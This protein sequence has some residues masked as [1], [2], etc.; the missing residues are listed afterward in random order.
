MPTLTFLDQLSIYNAKASLAITEAVQQENVDKANL[1]SAL[2]STANDLNLSSTT[3]LT[4]LTALINIGDLLEKALPPYFPLTV[5]YENLQKYAGIHNDL[6]GLDQGN[7]LHLTTQEKTTLF[8]KAGLSD[9]TWGNLQGSYT[10]NIEFAALF[11]QKQQQLNG[12]GL[13][14]ANGTSI[15]YDNTTYLTSASLS[16]TAAGGGL[17]GFYPNPGLSNNAVITQQLT[18]FDPLG[19]AGSITSADTIVSAIQKLNANLLTVSSGVG[20]ISSVSFSMPS[21][22]FNYTAGPYLSGAAPLSATFK[23]QAQNSVFAGPIGGGTGQPDFRALIAADLPTS[24]T[25]T[26]TFGSNITI[27]VITVDA[28]GRVTNISN[29]SSSSGGQVNTV[30]F[31]VPGGGVFTAINGGTPADVEIG[32]GLG[33]QNPN[34][35]W[36]GPQ[37]GSATAPGF[38]ALVAADI[39][40]GIPQANIDNLPSALNSK[41]S[42]GLN[43]SLIYMGNGSG[44]AAQSKVAGDLTAVYSEPSGINTATFTIANKAVTYAKFADV[45]DSPSNAIRPI[46]L[47]RFSSGQG[48]MQQMTLDPLAFNYN[49]TSGEIGLLVPNPPSLVD[50]GDLLTSS[51]ANVLERLPLPVD[52]ATKGYLLTPYVG[53]TAPLDIKLIWGEVGGDLTYSINTTGTPFPEFLIG[54]NKVTL[55]K[56]QTI[57]T[58][59][60]LGNNAVGAAIPAALTPENVVAM[61][62]LQ[63]SITGLTKGVVP[64]SSFTP[65][66]GKTKQDYFLAANNTW[67]LGVGGTTLPGGNDLQI[68]WND[69]GAFGGLNNMA[70]DNGSNTFVTTGTFGIVDDANNPN[71]GVY[72]SV[73]N[74]TGGAL[75]WAIPAITANDTFVGEDF[76]QSLK[77]KTLSSGTKIDIGAP[78]PGTIWYSSDSLGTLTSLT[79]AGNANKYLRVNAGGTALEWAGA[80]GGI[81]I[82]DPITGATQGSVLF[83]GIGGILEQ[84]NGDFFY[85][86]TNKFLGIGTAVPE[87]GLH[88]V[89]SGSANIKGIMNMHFDS[90]ADNQAKFIGARGRGNKNTPSALLA[91]DRI[92][93]LSARGYKTSAW[94]D[95]VGGFYIY[96]SEAWTN[97]AT[98]TYLTF[99]GAVAGG[100][101]VSEW[102]R[103]TATSTVSQLALGQASSKTGK[104][105]LYSSGGNFTTAIQA[106]AGAT[107]SETYI[108]PLTDGSSGEVLSTNGSGQ[109]AWAAAGSVVDGTYGQ[110]TVSGGGT[111]WTPV[112]IDADVTNNFAA[113]TGPVILANATGVTQQPS[114]STPT[115]VTAILDVF[116]GTSAVATAK[117]LVPAPVLVTDVGKFLRA[118][119]TWQTVAGSGDMVLASNQLNIGVKTFAV[120]SLAIRNAGATAS[121]T[122]ATAASAAR[123]ATLPDATGTLAMLSLAQTWTAAQTFNSSTL[124]LRNAGNTQTTTIA[125]GATAGSYI[126]TIPTLTANTSFAVLNL[127][128]TF[129]TR[130]TVSWANTTTNTTQAQITNTD[131]GTQVQLGVGITLSGTSSTPANRIGVWADWNTSMIGSGTLGNN[132]NFVVA[133]NTASN[134][135][136]LTSNTGNIYHT[137]FS[138]GLPGGIYFGNHSITDNVARSSANNHYKYFVDISP[139]AGLTIS[140]AATDLVVTGYIRYSANT[141]SL[142][143]QAFSIAGITTTNPYIGE[144]VECLVPNSGAGSTMTAARIGTAQLVNSQGSN[145][146]QTYNSL[147]GHF[148]EYNLNS[149]GNNTG[150][151]NY[152]QMVLWNF[153]PG[154]SLATGVATMLRIRRSVGGGSMLSKAAIYIDNQT[155]TASITNPR[156]GATVTTGQTYANPPWSVF[157]ESDK[158][159]FN[160]GILIDSAATLAST[161]TATAALEVVST[162]KG[163]RFPNMTTA[164]R[165][166]IANT[167][168]LVVFDTT[169]AKLFYNTGAA[170]LQIS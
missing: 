73:P 118:D 94:S 167:A 74:V 37:S 132:W 113:V 27:P 28:Y 14:R 147:I 4:A 108:L 65:A 24:G 6:D 101:T 124:L 109:L 100:T 15:T 149:G 127:A 136:F 11:D 156:T 95:T 56:I 68:Q 146:G 17:T 21:N 43:T 99:R 20:T 88:V 170:W 48:P 92:T 97:T 144:L 40:T 169:L 39:P 153:Y 57:A 85:D 81:A 33:N 165:T 164:Q 155:T 54:A 126:L 154:N 86:N 47:G 162:T 60:I 32:L 142:A 58:N 2:K 50:A 159:G 22:V 25:P 75:T 12:V 158:A 7:Y 70:T 79:A 128:Q 34:T 114:W 152:D 63:D 168:G 26:G 62:P 129:T 3:R 53:T 71:N 61:L 107:S 87:S 148:N 120:G 46:L 35:V 10:Q 145:V 133:R 66:A 30:T 104:L 59:T 106:S 29:V 103:F 77:D 9:I 90:N 19:P 18:S 138:V 102:G 157:A 83:A 137:T 131:T 84:E 16:S 82:G 115:D 117:G 125:G 76:A 89:T 23:S 130:Q 36:A 141:S 98:G 143:T 110:V 1:M 52:Y 44:V 166:A 31:D 80:T 49:S 105:L 45:P 151:T 38:R 55:G 13:V 64:A 42:A 112:N 163:V 161:L 116:E 41:L 140:S 119:G 122:M 51:G 96:A 160:G 91:N 121:T 123:T 8:A 78:D 139:S 150:F 93:S 5:T 67:Q 69:G 111:V 72:I 135:S 134:N